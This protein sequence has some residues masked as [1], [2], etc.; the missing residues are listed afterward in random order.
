MIVLSLGSSVQV[1]AEPDTQP[2]VSDP[3][4]PPPQHMGENVHVFECL[5]DYDMKVANKVCILKKCECT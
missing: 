2:P 1:K 4:A 5:T 3:S